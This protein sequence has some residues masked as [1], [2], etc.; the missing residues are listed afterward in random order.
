MARGYVIGQMTITDRA[1]YEKYRA[2]VMATVTAHGGEFLVRGGPQEI[3][4]GAPPGPRSV[5]LRFPSVEAAK[6]WYNSPE[7][8][9]IVPIRQGASTGALTIVEGV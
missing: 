1:Q 2:E 5:I 6:G 4:E 9:K 3:M 8:Q 7:Y